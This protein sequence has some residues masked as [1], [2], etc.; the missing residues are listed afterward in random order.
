[1]RR[2]A[3]SF[4]SCWLCLVALALVGSAARGAD[5]TMFDEGQAQQ[6][7]T[8]IQDKVGHRLR[9]LRLRITPDELSVQ[10]PNADT[11]GEIQTWRL[12]HAGLA[13]RLGLQVPV[14]EGSTRGAIPGGGTIE[15]NLVDIDAAGLALV[16]KLAADALARARLQ[17]P[18]RVTEMEILRLPKF[19]GPAARDPYWQIHVEG[20]EEEADISAKLTG[21]ITTADLRRTKRAENLNLLAGGPDFDEMIERIRSELK[22]KWIFHYIEIDKDTI[23]FDIHLLSVSNPR[24]MRFTATLSDIK[25]Y[26]T[27][28]PHMVFPGTPADDPFSLADVDLSMMTKLEDAAKQRLQIADGLVQRVIISKPHRENRSTVEW[29]VDVKSAHA[30]LFVMPNM[31][32]VEQGSVTFDTTGKVVRTKYA[33]GHAVQQANLFDPATLRK[34]IDKIAERLGP[35]AQVSE[36]VVTE[37][38]I[39]IT[40]QDPQ[41]PGKFAAFAYQ[42]EDVARDSGIGQTMANAFGGGPDWLWDLALL[43]PAIV[44]SLTA[45][46]QQT[47]ARLGIVHGK[48]ER[49]TF[50]K[51]KMFHRGNDKVLVEIR[52]SG[53]GKNLDFVTFDLAGNLP[54]FRDTSGIRI[55]RPNAGPAP[56]DQDEDDCTRSLD[57]EKVI[58]ACTKLIEAGDTPHNMAVDYYDRGNAYKSRQDY[59]HALVDYTEALKLDPKYAHAYLNRGVVFVAKEDAERALADFTRSIELDPAQRLGYVNRALVY[60]ALHNYDAAIGDYNRAITMGV[61]AADAYAGRGEAYAGRGAFQKAL[62]DY[63]EALKRGAADPRT[64]ALR[65]N[66]NRALNKLDAA[67]ADYD[68]AIKLD[69]NYAAAWHGRGFAYRLRGDFDRA[70]ADYGE[71]IKRDPRLVAAYNDRG[72]AYRLK[73]DIEHA[74]ADYDQAAELDPKSAATYHRRGYVH[75]LAGDMPKALADLTQASALDPGDA[76]LALLLEIVG[77]RSGLPGRLKE[78]S[79][80][81]DM[82]SWPAPVIR[83]YLGQLTAPAVLAAAADRDP[84]TARSR[85]CEANFYTGELALLSGRKEAAARLFSAAAMDC[86]LSVSEW[87]S[88]AAELKAMGVTPPQGKR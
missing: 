63:D 68:A 39:R 20:V 84:Q 6:A 58:P 11:P 1:M 34:A 31:P 76:Y 56:T 14:L 4:V 22:D 79:G 78:L 66:A 12:S 8:A 36:L 62:A 72:S 70:I 47:M 82:T 44:Q 32:P 61:D 29:Q 16:P 25:T 86:P 41:A 73:G 10:I 59:D 3:G 50:S 21:E 37:Q 55:V 35:H 5:T 60:N 33:P 13:A 28:M 77:R 57:P 52:A 83:L 71:A 65:G 75:Y 2:V 69:A 54:Q 43:Q 26:N 53:D 48:I 30:P 88:A 67:I 9:V 80:K 27:S 87:E 45:L 74:V 15:E 49:I 38:N 19:L 42:D 23:N 18:G 17:Q 81:L 7:F 24:I 51:D 64:L 85:I 46:E 40:A